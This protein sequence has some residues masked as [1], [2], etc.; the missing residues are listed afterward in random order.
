VRGRESQK[1]N[2]FKKQRALVKLSRYPNE[3]T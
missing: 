2:F 1:R 3:N